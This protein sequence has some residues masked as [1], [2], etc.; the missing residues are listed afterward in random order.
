MELVD[1][2]PRC[3]DIAQDRLDLH[4]RLLAALTLRV[5]SIFAVNAEAVSKYRRGS[6]SVVRVRQIV[7]YLAH[8]ALGLS[9][10][11]VALVLNRDRS[12]VKLALRVIEDGRDDPAF[13]QFLACLEASLDIERGGLS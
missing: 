4:N 1:C 9:P 11:E 2:A 3:R 6:P 12:S 13:D 5:S 8:I 7:M 10:V